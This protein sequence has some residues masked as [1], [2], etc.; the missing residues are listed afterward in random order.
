M[1]HNILALVPLVLAFGERNKRSV[2]GTDLLLLC[3]SV[4]NFFFFTILRNTLLKG[5][6]KRKKGRKDEWNGVGFGFTRSEHQDS[7]KILS[8]S[9]K[10][11]LLQ[12]LLTASFLYW[13]V[14]N[15]NMVSSFIFKV[16]QDSFSVSQYMQPQMCTII[17]MNGPFM[18]VWLSLLPVLNED[19]CTVRH[20]EQT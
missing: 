1:I 5:G 15:E 18:I 9:W 19:Q 7:F 20:N 12:R 2:I 14:K 8:G 13:V 16:K 17:N 6:E 4:L 10:Q 11:S 3:T